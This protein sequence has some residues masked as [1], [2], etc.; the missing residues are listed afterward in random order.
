M[1]GNVVIHHNRYNRSNTPYSAHVPEV[2]ICLEIGI[3]QMFI[4]HHGIIFSLHTTEKTK[5]G[6]GIDV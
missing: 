2:T 1:Q 5:T 3:L 6:R 4:F